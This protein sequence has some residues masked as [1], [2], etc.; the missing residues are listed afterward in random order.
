MIMRQSIGTKRRRSGSCASACG[1]TDDLIDW[2]WLAAVASITRRGQAT[3][4]L[5]L[6]SSI[7]Y[8]ASDDPQPLFLGRGK[9]GRACVSHPPTVDLDLPPLARME[10][11]DG[12]WKASPGVGAPPEDH[13]KPQTTADPHLWD[14]AS[15]ALAMPVAS[16]ET[17]QSPN[18]HRRQV[19]HDAHAHASSALWCGY[20]RPRAGDGDAALGDRARQSFQRIPAA[21]PAGSWREGSPLD[22][23]DGRSPVSMSPDAGRTSQAMTPQAV[24]RIWEPVR[25]CINRTPVGRAMRDCA[26]AVCMRACACACVRSREPVLLRVRAHGRLRRSPRRT[27]PDPFS[28]AP[29]PPRRPPAL[30]ILAPLSLRVSRR[31]TLRARW[32]ACAR[33]ATTL[34][35]TRAGRAAPP[36]ARSRRSSHPPPPPRRW[37]TRP[38]S[39]RPR[40]PT[41]RDRPPTAPTPPTV[42]WRRWP[43][44]GSPARPRR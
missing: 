10:S 41:H 4:L 15:K 28:P 2:P 19:A 13:S 32:I 38:S 5:Y 24:A 27:I 42:R 33:A 1:L 25:C 14:V 17:S 37:R 9:R 31:Y 44:W 29:P 22:L 8:E 36:P 30:G 39:R 26:S 21:I 11:N 20:R 3:P 12:I 34:S 18:P 6:T 7:R 16:V 35:T 40:P 23:S 43:P